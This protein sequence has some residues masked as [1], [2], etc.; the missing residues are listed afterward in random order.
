MPSVKP[1]EVTEDE[2]QGKEGRRLF[3]VRK[4]KKIGN[5]KILAIARERNSANPKG[6]RPIVFFY[7]VMRQ[8]P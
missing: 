3:A 2:S 1:P 5:L 7:P 8:K 6:D 4:K